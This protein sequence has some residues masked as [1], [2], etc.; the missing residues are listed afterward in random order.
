MVNAIWHLIEGKQYQLFCVDSIDSESFF[1]GWKRAE[2]KARRHI[3][4][5][6]YIM[7]EVVP[8]IKKR[9][10]ADRKLGAHGVSW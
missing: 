1:C 9:G 10:K 6:R 5:E 2:D 4:Y 8:F 3:D 7:E